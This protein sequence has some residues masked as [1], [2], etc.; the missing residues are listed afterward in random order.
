MRFAPRA[1]GLTTLTLLTALLILFR[2]GAEPV[3][4]AA[5]AQ[6]A[7]DADLAL[8]PLDAVGFV[9]VRAADLWKNDALAGF[10]Q[11]FEKAGPKAI[12]ALESSFVPK[13]STFERMTGF[14]LL[15]EARQQPVPFVVLRF[16]ADFDP[17]L[18]AKT[19]LPDGKRRAVARQ[20][21][22][23]S[24]QTDFELFFPD[25]RHIVISMP[26]GMDVLLNR[27]L[28]KSGPMSHG[29][30]LAASGKPVVASVSIAA[31][32]IPPEG[33]EELPADVRPLLKAE[34]VTIS[35]DLGASATIDLVG[36]F[37]NAADAD[38]AE[39]A[40]KALAGFAR[41]ELAKIKAEVEERIFDP[42]A[43]GPRALE[44]LPEAVLFVFSLGA[45]NHADEL[46]AN[47]GALVK[48]NGNNLTASVTLPKE[49]IASAGGFVAIGS[50]LL[51]PAVAKVRAAAA[52]AQSQNNLKQIALAIHNYH[53]A[54]GHLPQDILDKDGNAL[55]S[56]RVAI[57]PF[58]EQDN[59]YRQFK[60]DEPWNSPNN[61]K[62]SEVAIKTYMSPNAIPA[63]PPGMTHY[64]GFSGP[65]AIFEKG[66]KLKFGDVTD[67]L[68][69][70]IL[71]VEAG[72]P[73]PWAKPGDFPFDPKKELP[74]LA[75]PGVPDVVNIAF[76]DGSVRSLVLKNLPEKTLKAMITRA[77]GEIVDRD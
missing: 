44:D 15:D 22:Y 24:P 54:Y 52:R 29:L 67:G 25:N 75:L 69:N 6:P 13:V 56:W 47:P 32:P 68:S 26:G 43:K 19:Y 3:V 35:L 51:L 38:D 16:S 14:L 74:K 48:R 42:K 64:K 46:L 59:L 63:T 66:K 4:A 57:L 73:V 45:I 30:Q 33:L 1:V 65:G 76:A 23:S 18:V 10:R 21:V 31:L 70:T 39:K 20:P 40:I 77:G 36:G 11:T 7:L 50:A 55:L 28:P 5:A 41:K 62:W 71:V 49:L 12:A 17:V 8:V 60:L 34:H 9:H 37:K 58:I 61:L 2:P 27:E 72:D 53:D